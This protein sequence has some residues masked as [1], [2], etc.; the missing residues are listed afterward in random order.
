VKGL[1]V[2]VMTC[3]AGG[4]GNASIATLLK[5]VRH[6]LGGNDAGHKDWKVAP[7]DYTM[8]RLTGRLH[9]FF[10]D[11]AKEAGFKLAFRETDAAPLNVAWFRGVQLHL[12][13]G[14]LLIAGLLA[15]SAFGL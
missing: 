9:Q 5:D 10:E 14:V 3:G 7:D 4:I 6:R 15:A 11:K 13:F 8:E 12:Q 2:G 1:P